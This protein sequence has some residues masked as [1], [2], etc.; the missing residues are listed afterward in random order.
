LRRV[1]PSTL[2]ERTEPAVYDRQVDVWV[3]KRSR[4]SRRAVT[5][6][7]AA[8]AAAISLVAVTASFADSRPRGLAAAVPPERS[9][10]IFVSPAGSDGG[11]CTRAVPCLTLNR[12]YRAARPGDV[13]EVAGGTYPGQRIDEDPSKTSSRHV[14]F[15]PA[16]SALVTVQGMLDFGLA[17][18]GRRSARHVT[19]RNFAVTN[20]IRAWAT[21]ED[22]VWE[23]IDAN[24]FLIDGG[25]RITVRGGDFGPCRAGAGQSCVSKIAGPTAENIL[26][27][28]ALFHDITTS[29][30]VRYHVECMFLRAGTN[31]VIRR[32]RFVNCEVFDIFLQG[33][34]E[35]S[36]FSNVTIEQNVFAAPLKGD[37]TRRDTA[38]AF[39]GQKAFG[40][41]FIRRNSFLDS[42]LIFETRFPEAYEDVRI[43][44]NIL[45]RG[46]TAC[47]GPVTYRANVWQDG[48]TCAASDRAVPYGYELVAGALRPAERSA[49]VVRRAFAEAA[50]ARKLNTAVRRLARAGVPAP[51]RDRWSVSALRT[52]LTDKAYLGGSYG[53]AG[54]HPALVSTSMWRAVQKRLK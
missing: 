29:D 54:S 44:G 39:S 52:L 37:G 11:A 27:E 53:A 2:V 18:I 3:T 24:A 25:R 51:G 1:V 41:I 9:A 22:L 31:V 16:P 47:F 32:N 40:G 42:G 4:V 33:Q 23:N 26:V 46:R 49:R 48:A 34:R 12:A 21:S 36:R 14:V 15:R 6:W 35:I 30:P 5:R 10:T 20:E 43:Q 8:T 7:S 45:R 28:R 38:I 13:V 50:R 19:I 17:S